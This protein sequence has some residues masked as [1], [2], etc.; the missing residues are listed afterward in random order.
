MSRIFNTVLA[1]EPARRLGNE[2]DQ[3]GD[4]SWDDVEKSEGDSPGAVIGDRACGVA[5]GVDDKASA[6]ET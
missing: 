1:K 5:D 6:D 3:R 2:K 4:D